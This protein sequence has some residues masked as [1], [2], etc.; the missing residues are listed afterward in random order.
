MTR[1]QGTPNTRPVAPP[2]C[3]W[4]QKVI[5]ATPHETRYGQGWIHNATNAERCNLPP[6]PNGTPRIAQPESIRP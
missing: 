4:C 5:Y 3:R 1:H 6:A 2:Q